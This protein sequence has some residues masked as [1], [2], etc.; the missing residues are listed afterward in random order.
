MPK[1]DPQTTEIAK[2]VAMFI[3][4]FTLASICWHFGGVDYT[5]RTFISGMGC[6]MSMLVGMMFMLARKAF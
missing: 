4:G 2:D 5:D 1:P 6:A 3:I